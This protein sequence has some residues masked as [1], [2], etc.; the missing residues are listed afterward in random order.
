MSIRYSRSLRRTAL[1]MLTASAYACSS[2]SPTT[3][4]DNQ[5][6][7]LDAV[8]TEAS[9]PAIET[10]GT[11]FVAVGFSMPG[12]TTLVPSSCAYDGSS[13]SFVC[14]Q[15]ATGGLTVERS[16]ILYDAK[17]NRQ[18]QFGPSTAAVQMKAHVAGTLAVATGTLT[19]DAADDRT[20]S[21]LLTAQHVLNSTSS[22]TT[23]GTFGI[24]SSP[25]SQMHSTS[26]TKIEN[27]V[28]PS[29]ANR[30]PGPGTLTAD[31]TSSFGT[32][33]ALSSHV[34]ATFNGTRCVVLSIT[35]GGIS[36]TVTIDL[37]QGD[38]TAGCTP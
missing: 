36:E 27:L 7:S 29:T 1:A 13:Q 11:R 14:H 37:S 2:D 33:P 4:V 15:I 9:Q 25:P 19:M 21:G 17:G 26:T 28:L 20:V 22:S 5:S 34:Q 12:G 3:P 24:G 16:F 23:D 31:A 6:A 38:V 32:L 10:V 18:S 8:L 35:S 30:W